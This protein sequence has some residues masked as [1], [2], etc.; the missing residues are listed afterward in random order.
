VKHLKKNLE[1]IRARKAKNLTQEQLA[2]LLECKKT[3]ISNWENGYSKPTLDVAYKV[4]ELLELDINALFFSDKVQ[5]SQ[6]NFS[7]VSNT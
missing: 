4:S 6:T 5:E 2:E 3:T 7:E 1:L